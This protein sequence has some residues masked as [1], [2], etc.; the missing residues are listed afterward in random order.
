MIL[1]S[2]HLICHSENKIWQFSFVVNSCDRSLK[3]AVAVPHFPLLCSIRKQH[4]KYCADGPSLSQFKNIFS[5]NLCSPWLYFIVFKLRKLAYGTK[6]HFLIF[7]VHT[8]NYV[9]VDCV[10]CGL[11]IHFPLLIFVNHWICWRFIK[12]SIVIYTCT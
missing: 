11:S 9:C 12:L 5:W 7:N 6:N 2:E 10:V 1:T 3:L 8:H 4:T